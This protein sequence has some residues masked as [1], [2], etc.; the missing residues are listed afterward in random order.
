M[1]L[2]LFLFLSMERKTITC[3]QGFGAAES[4]PPGG[5]IPVM[6]ME[7]ELCKMEWRWN[8]LGWDG[9]RMDWS[10]VEG[11]PWWRWKQSC[12][13]GNEIMLE[14]KLI[15]TDFDGIRMDW[16][17]VSERQTGDWHLLDIVVT[18]APVHSQITWK[19]YVEWETG[20]LAFAMQKFTFRFFSWFT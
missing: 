16:S 8:E 3:S 5:G 12:V 1:I 10:N 15:E 4:N 6:E 19:F 9:I 11:L 2:W 18:P 13:N 20:Y 14:S 7:A 17:N